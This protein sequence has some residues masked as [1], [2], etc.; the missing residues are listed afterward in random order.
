V[1]VVV[2]EALFVNMEG[3][4]NGILGETDWYISQSTLL[5]NGGV[6]TGRLS[7]RK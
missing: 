1:R 5:I 3:E 4:E 6:P 2:A 7:R